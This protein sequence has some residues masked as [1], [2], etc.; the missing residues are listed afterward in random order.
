MKACR[1]KQARDQDGREQRRDDTDDQRRSE[2]LHGTRTE[3]EQHDTGDQRRDV[4]VDDGRHGI[5]VSFGHRN[6]QRLA[7]TQL[8]LDSLV[9]DH[10]GVDGHTHRQNDTG[11]TGQRQHGS[12]RDEHAEQEEQ[13]A[14]QCDLATVPALL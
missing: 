6:A 3:D 2:A 11:D 10:V 13:V 12:E 7:H 5:L 9:N 14:Y 4:T 8:L 1:R